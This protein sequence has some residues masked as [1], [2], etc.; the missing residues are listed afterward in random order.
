M[1]K[2][3]PNKEKISKQAHKSH[4]DYD[5]LI[6]LGLSNRQYSAVT[7]RHHASPSTTPSAIVPCPPCPLRVPASPAKE[8]HLMK[9]V[10]PMI[11]PC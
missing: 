7:G 3:W 5:P 9:A 1:D 6:V 8:A 10:T 2:E 4:Q 11:N